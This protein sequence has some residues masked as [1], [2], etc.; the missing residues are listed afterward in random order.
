MSEIVA[1]QPPMSGCL[2]ATEAE[3]VW[4]W[5]KNQLRARCRTKWQEGKHFA[6]IAGE[7]RYS[8]EDIERW[9]MS[10]HTTIE[11]SS[12]SG[13]VGN[14]IR[15]PSIPNPPK[16]TFRRRSAKRNAP[17]TDLNLENHGILSEPTSEAS[18]TLQPKNL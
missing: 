5:S 7:V 14:N 18:V 12:D 2:C 4:G 16:P 3:R 1:L 11:S 15:P 13:S 8:Y 9:L 10:K 17:K 6:I